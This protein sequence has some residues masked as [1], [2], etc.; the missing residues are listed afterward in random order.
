[1]AKR[2]ASPEAKSIPET[3]SITW[4]SVRRELNSTRN[5]QGG[6]DYDKVRRQ[7]LANLAAH[8]GRSAV[9]YA[10]DF[11][12]EG[13]IRH[14]Q[15]AM[16][17]NPQDVR[18]LAEVVRGVTGDALDLILHSPGG[19]GEAAESIVAVLRSQFKHVRVLVPVM[20]K[21]AATMIALAANE[22]LMPVSAELGPIDPQ[23]L[24]SDGR[25]GQRMTPAQAIIDEVQRAQQAVATKQADFPVW[26]AKMQSQPPGLYQQALNAVKL[27]K[28]LVQRWLEGHMFAG[29]A[30]A[31][32]MA[33]VIVN[34]LGDHNQFLSHARRVDVETLEQMGAKIH[35]ITAVD[36][37]L[38][39]LL[40]ELWYTVEH[41]FQNTPVIKMWE[42]SSGVGLFMAFQP[43]L[44]MAPVGPMPPQS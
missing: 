38:W 9:L 5:D 15:N 41:T 42:N 29:E 24:L 33:Q 31:K 30:N 13:K 6:I 36:R 17:I 12:N 25:G 39:E 26:L 4:E 7:K 37:A 44:I 19:S 3:K 2:N 34:Y 14:A 27:S 21:S 18:G 16:A 8:T 22:I 35:N 43:Q 11:L 32:A 23:F 28:E 10:T 40:E 20:A 1:M